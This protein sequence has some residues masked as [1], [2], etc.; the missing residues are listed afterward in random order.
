MNQPKSRSDFVDLIIAGLG[1]SAIFWLWDTG[2]ITQAHEIY[3][4]AGALALTL[5]S[6]RGGAR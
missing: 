1:V 5:I 6:L 4:F 3:I 2:R